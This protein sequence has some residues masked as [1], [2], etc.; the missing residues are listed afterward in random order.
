MMVGICRGSQ[1]GLEM[2]REEKRREAG[3]RRES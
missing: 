3:G 2:H 1:G